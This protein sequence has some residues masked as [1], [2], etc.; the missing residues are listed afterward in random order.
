MPG[1]NKHDIM[2]VK[3]ESKYIIVNKVVILT[4]L[5]KWDNVIALQSNCG[6][7]FHVSFVF[8]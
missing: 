5:I 1:L 7:L 4:I 6:E 3:P 2:I 8:V